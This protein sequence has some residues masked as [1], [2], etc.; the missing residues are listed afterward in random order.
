M[1]I[2]MKNRVNRDDPVRILM[3]TYPRFVVI[4]AVL[5]TLQSKDKIK[6]DLLEEIIIK[7]L[8]K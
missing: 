6:R 7:E 1:N 2:K 5:K 3:E 8:K 4:K